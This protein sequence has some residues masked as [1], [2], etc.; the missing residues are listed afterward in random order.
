MSLRNDGFQNNICDFQKQICYESNGILV[1]RKWSKWKDFLGSEI[2]FDLIF[3]TV[4]GM[5]LV[6]IVKEKDSRLN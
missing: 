1:L 6:C 5:Y 4:F 2:I 3:Q